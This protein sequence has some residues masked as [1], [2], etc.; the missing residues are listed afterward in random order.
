MSEADENEKNWQCET[1]DSHVDREN[2]MRRGA[3]FVI[4]Y[5]LARMR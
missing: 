4:G 5:A 3:A 2:S 1:R